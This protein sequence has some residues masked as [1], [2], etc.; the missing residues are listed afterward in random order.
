[1]KVISLNVISVKKTL[2]NET[3]SICLYSSEN[4]IEPKLY[5]MNDQL[6]KLNDIEEMFIA[7]VHVVISMY[8]LSKGN[9]GYKGNVLNIQQD[10]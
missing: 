5:L 10:V 1:M 9:I 7:R 3:I 4:N 8:R 6:P 2:A